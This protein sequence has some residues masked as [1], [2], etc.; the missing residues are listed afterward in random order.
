MRPHKYDYEIMKLQYNKT[1]TN[2]VRV[3]RMAKY[4]DRY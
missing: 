1:S 2:K 3:I 4:L